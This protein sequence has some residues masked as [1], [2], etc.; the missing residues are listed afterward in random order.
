MR[1][2]ELIDE[3]LQGIDEGNFSEA[4]KKIEKLRDDCIKAN[5]DKELSYIEELEN[6][7]N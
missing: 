2:L 7:L 1:I 3:A 5:L 4:K 6:S